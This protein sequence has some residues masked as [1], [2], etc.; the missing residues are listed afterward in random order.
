VSKNKPVDVGHLAARFLDVHLPMGL[1]LDEVIVTGEN[2]HVDSHPLQAKLPQPGALEVRVGEASL[3]DFLNHKG[4]GGLSGFEVKLANGLIHVGAV[5]T[6]I[7]QLNVGAVCKLRIENGT[8]LFVDLDR[9]EAIGGSGAY[10]LVK[11][12]LDSIN[13][14]LDA[15]D[16]PLDAVLNTVHVENGWLVLKG[17]VAPKAE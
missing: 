6:V 3:A 5:A 9:V 4:P 15:K 12:Q 2:L 8:Q 1:T 13:P 16:L 17:T 14:V 11:R 7:I 10:N